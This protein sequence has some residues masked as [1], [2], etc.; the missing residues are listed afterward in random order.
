MESGGLGIVFGGDTEIVEK[1]CGGWFT[2]SSGGQLV[3]PLIQ[4]GI[5]AQV[6]GRDMAMRRVGGLRIV[7][8]GCTKSPLAGNLP[9]L[10]AAKACI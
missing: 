10:L 2:W 5:S 3:R 7:K 1:V 9:G 4:Q 6:G 8:R